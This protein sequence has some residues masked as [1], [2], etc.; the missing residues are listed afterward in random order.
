MEPPRE[1][2]MVMVPVDLM[3]KLILFAE[4]ASD[5]LLA[6]YANAGSAT[7]AHEAAEMGCRVVLDAGFDLNG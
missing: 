4:A 1:T 3:R 6:E 7:V 2:E 5:S